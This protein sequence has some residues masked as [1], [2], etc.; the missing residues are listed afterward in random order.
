[1]VKIS[2]DKSMVQSNELINILERYAEFARISIIFEFG[3]I[4]SIIVECTNSDRDED[5]LAKELKRGLLDL[6]AKLKIQD[7]TSDIVEKIIDKVFTKH[8]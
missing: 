8:V 4:N 1:M 7:T 6:N 2:I 5:L 3:K